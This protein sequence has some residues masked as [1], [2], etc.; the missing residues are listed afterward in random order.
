MT[1]NWD[2]V[3][4]SMF[5]HVESMGYGQIEVNGVRQRSEIIWA[6]ATC[7]FRYR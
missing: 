2:V 1:I 7:R 5:V 3:V 4:G 6:N